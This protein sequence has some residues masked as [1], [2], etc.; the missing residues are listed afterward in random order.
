[1]PET[2]SKAEPTEFD[3]VMIAMD[4]VDTLRHQDLIVERELNEEDRERALV[5]RLREIYDA[6]GIDVPDH[7]LRDGVKAM[8]EDRFH[9]QPPAPSLQVSLAKFYVRRDRWLK[10]VSVA[11]L[12]LGVGWGA[13]HYGYAQPRTQRAERLT[14]ELSTV[15]PQDLASHRDKARS[16]SLT[17]RAREYIE[18]TY[19]DGLAAAT[20]GDERRARSAVEALE[21]MQTDLNRSLTV[22]IVSRPGEYSGVFRIPDDAPT[23]RNYYLIVEAVDLRGEAQ[24]VEISSEEDQRTEKVKK[25]GVRVSETAFNRVMRDKQEDQIVQ[26]AVVGQKRRGALFPEYSVETTGGAI[27]DW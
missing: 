20:E 13:Y 23:T 6:Q 27:L 9:Y 1:M 5:Q 12:V 19:Q 7:V 8:E 17:D 21:A 11:A 22:R 16:L 24:L 2:H 3:D 4:I 10:P 18:A 26:N 25:W 15:I 14:F